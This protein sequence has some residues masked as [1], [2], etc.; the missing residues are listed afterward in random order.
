MSLAHS[1][2]VNQVSQESKFSL[3]FK[4]WKQ[5]TLIEKLLLGNIPLTAVVFIPQIIAMYMAHSSKGVS[6]AMLVISAWM[7]T[8]GCSDLYMKKNWT[9]F[10]AMS[11][12]LIGCITAI[13]FALYF[14]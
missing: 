7:Q 3:I 12:S 4:K 10:I 9:H 8:I 13:I 1:K 2:S 6:I 5:L 11:F 14:R